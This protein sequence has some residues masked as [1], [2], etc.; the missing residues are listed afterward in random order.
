MRAWALTLAFPAATGQGFA[1]YAP[2]FAGSYGQYLQGG[3]A[4]TA[5]Y[6]QL[7]G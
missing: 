1:R 4:A 3:P 7:G 5:G 6:A 2:Q